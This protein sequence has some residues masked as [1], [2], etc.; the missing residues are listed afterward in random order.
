MPARPPIQPVDI[1]DFVRTHGPGLYTVGL[2]HGRQVVGVVTFD[3]ALDRIYIRHMGRVVT[4]WIA[5]VDTIRT[6]LPDR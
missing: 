1:V 5:D 4:A 6:G 3:A 2:H